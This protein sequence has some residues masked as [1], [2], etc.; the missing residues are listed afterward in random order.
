[1]ILIAGP[2][3][4]ET[5]SQILTTAHQLAAVGITC[6]RAGVWKPRTMPGHFEGVGEEAFAWLKEMST[7]EHLTFSTEV[8]SAA[9]TRIAV[10]AGASMIWLGARTTTNP[11]LV[12]EIADELA[13][14]NDKPVVLVKNPLS[15]D[16]NLWQGA[17]QRIA[18][19]VGLDHVM[20][21]HRGFQNGQPSPYRNVPMWSI[22]IELRTRLTHLRMLL[23]ASHM[24]GACHLIPELCQKALDL[25]YDGLM[26]EVH[27]SPADALS[28]A[29]Q[30]LTPDE[31]RQMLADLHHRHQ[32]SDLGLSRLRSQIDETDDALWQLILQRMEVS[33]KIGSYKKEHDI[34]VFQSDRFRQLVEHRLEW[35]RENGLDEKMVQDIMHA[36]HAESCRWQI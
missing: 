21:V 5:R 9:Q 2:C 27:C 14:C 18:D 6:F 13:N 30:Q 31:L 10:Q 11:F 12:Q 7:T 19:V 22:A 32:S 28:D 24:A 35:A 25:E 3:A 15:P 33:R 23:D 29:Q 17:I 4:A 34:P 8:A 26:L 36:L 20:A 1:M 16:V